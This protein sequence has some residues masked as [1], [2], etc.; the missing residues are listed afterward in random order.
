LKEE[1]ECRT[2]QERIREARIGQDRTDRSVLCSTYSS[3]PAARE[4]VE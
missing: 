4:R 1:E 2:G 3:V